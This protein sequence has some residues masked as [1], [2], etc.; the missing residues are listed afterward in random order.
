[1]EDWGEA[2]FMVGYGG[3]DEA[4]AELREL[5]A[6]VAWLRRVEALVREDLE[7]VEDALGHPW[8]AMRDLLGE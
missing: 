7:A 3:R 1:M 4:E 8:H 2:P 6:E 5:Q